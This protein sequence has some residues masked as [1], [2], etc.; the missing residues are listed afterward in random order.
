MSS[1]GQTGQPLAQSHLG[2]VDEKQLDV[3][4]LNGDAVAEWLT[5]QP[6]RVVEVLGAPRPGLVA[7]QR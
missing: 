4:A 7:V 2:R 6:N 1:G 3:A 5:T